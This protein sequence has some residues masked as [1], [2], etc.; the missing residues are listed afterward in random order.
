M[1][2]NG[3]VHETTVAMQSNKYY[4][5]VF[6]CMCVCARVS[7][8]VGGWVWVQKRGCARARVG[9]LIQ[10]AT[11]RS[12]TVCIPSD[13]VIFSDISHKRHVFREN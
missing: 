12:H 1:Q 8:W 4:I 9:L 5:F 7:E 10:Y 6:V 3:N 13:S 2:I 11:S